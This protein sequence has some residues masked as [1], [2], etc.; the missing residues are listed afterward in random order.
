MPGLNPEQLTIVGLL[1]AILV[2]G[3]R[4]DWVFGWTYRE[5]ADD[6]TEDRNYWRSMALRTLGVAEKVAKDG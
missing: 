5:M 4:R 3:V 6:L 1:L 2:G